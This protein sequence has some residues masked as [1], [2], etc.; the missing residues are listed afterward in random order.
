MTY[1]PDRPLRV[2]VADDEPLVLRLVCDILGGEHQV[3]GLDSGRDVLRRYHENRYDLLIL[4]SAIRSPTG[5]EI[6]ARVREGGDR[7]PIILM[8]GAAVTTKFMGPFAFT[9]RVDLLRKP[10]G[11]R[12]LKGAVQ[13][14]RHSPES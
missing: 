6:A 4:D 5:V 10:F 3:D 8:T 13:R 14:L 9:Y 1:D 12:D 2:L 11:V 7:I